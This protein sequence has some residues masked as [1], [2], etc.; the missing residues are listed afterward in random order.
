MTGLTFRR[1]TAEDRDTLAE[2]HSRVWQT[3]MAELAPPEALARL[4]EAH[5]RKQWAR[6]LAEPRQDECVLLAERDGRAVAMGAAGSPLHPA[7][8]GRGELRA[9]DVDGA[10]Q[11]QGIGRQLIGRLAQHLI[12]CGYDRIG[13][14]VVEGNLPAIAFYEALG[15]RIVGHYTDLGPIWKSQD[16]VMAWDERDDVLRLAAC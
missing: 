16:L 5:R 11:R 3:V 9:I 14:S 8:E 12:Q 10:C 4:D 7:F 2:L 6:V 1:A 13:L 15:G